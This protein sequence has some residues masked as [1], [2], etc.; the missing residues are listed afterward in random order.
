MKI[1]R[2]PNLPLTILD[3]INN[4]NLS[5]FVGAGTSRVL[6]CWGWDQL[7]KKLIEKCFSM[8]CINFR[9]REILSECNDYK[10]I[11]TICRHLLERNGSDNSFLETLKEG[12]KGDEHQKK[13]AN[14]YA[15]LIRIPALYITTNFDEHFDEFFH[16]DRIVFRDEGFKFDLISPEK[17]YHIHGSIMDSKTL[18]LTIPDYFSRYNSPH[19]KQFLNRIFSE[20]VILFIGYGMTEFELLDFLIGKFDARN[21][22]RFILQPYFKGNEDI[23]AFD[24]YYYNSMGVSI[25]P[26]EYD[27]K[28]HSQLYNVIKS[29]NNEIGR[30]SPYLFEKAN[31]IDK[32]VEKPW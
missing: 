14:I 23:A 30:V 27:D 28:G 2:E 21:R 31:E 32:V 26:F 18:V 16:K 17:L 25:I 19:F 7:A 8:G 6:G 11:I 12:C 5:I 4:R 3:A 15:E 29:W 9:Q 1:E 22:A 24:Q 20:K 10:K 13:D